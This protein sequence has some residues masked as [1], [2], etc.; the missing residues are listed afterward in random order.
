MVTISTLEGGGSLVTAAGEL[1]LATV[2]DLEDTLE[3]A[4]PAGRLV[5]DLSGLTFLDS[6]ALRLLIATIRRVDEAGGSISLVAPEPG[7]AR[8]LEI[9]AID[10]MVAVHTSL[11]DAL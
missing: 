10:K 1:D 9:A 8:V 3:R 4:D 5:L 7:V 11:D 6:S 2:P